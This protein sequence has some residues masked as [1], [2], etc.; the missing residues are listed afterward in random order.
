[1]RNIEID[2]LKIKNNEMTMVIAFYIH[3]IGYKRM[4]TEQSKKA[5]K[6]TIINDLKTAL[7]CTNLT[8]YHS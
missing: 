1:M 7:V 6:D 4:K 2:H 3:K 5:D 8:H